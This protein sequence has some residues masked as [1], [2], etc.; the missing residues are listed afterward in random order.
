MGRTTAGGRQLLHGVPLDVDIRRMLH[1]AHLRHAFIDLQSVRRGAAWLESAPAASDVLVCDAE[2]DLDLAAIA[3][4]ARPLGPAV[5]WAGSAG[6]AHQLPQCLGM[7]K[8]VH[9]HQTLPVS[10]APLIF[11]IGSPS[12]VSQEQAALLAGEKVVSLVYGSATGEALAAALARG[13]DVLVRAHPG[14]PVDPGTLCRQLAHFVAPHVT[15]AG[16]LVLSGGETAR[17]VLLALGIPGLRL[18]SEV[19]PGVPLSL[20]LGGGRPLPVITKAGAF[21]RPDTLSRCR[22]VM[23]SKAKQC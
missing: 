19:E 16:G 7:A 1:A 5:V 20:A 6:L 15:N 2:S 8:K 10:A 23:K 3:Q 18:I 9:G 13:D 17:A 11:V 21:G 22:A 12:S 14:A 4:A